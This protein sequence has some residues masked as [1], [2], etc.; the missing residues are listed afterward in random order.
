MCV[1]VIVCAYACVCVYV[2]TRSNKGGT[3]LIIAS[4]C[5]HLD[6]VKCLLRLPVVDV[7]AANAQG[8]TA[9]MR[10]ADKVRP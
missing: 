10:A 7:N 4:E 9:L 5:G 2:S 6:S 1:C 8:F 3:P